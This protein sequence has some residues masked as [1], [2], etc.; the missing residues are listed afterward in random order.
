[1]LTYLSTY[2]YLYRYR[3]R[4]RIRWIEEREIENFL[5]FFII[6]W[7]MKEAVYKALYPDIRLTWKDVYILKN[8]N[9][10]KDMDKDDHGKKPILNYDHRILKKY[11]QLMSW[12]SHISLSHDGDYLVACAFILKQSSPSI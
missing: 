3:E 10:D 1:M 5:L 11:P 6:R 8:D 12:S 7:G 4:E 2:R 9:K